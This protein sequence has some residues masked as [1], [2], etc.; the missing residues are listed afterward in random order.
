MNNITLAGT[1][2]TSPSAAFAELRERPR[3][4]TLLIV[5]I[6]ALA[7]QQFWFFN[8]V[9]FEWLKDHMFSG[10]ERFDSMQP[11]ARERMMSGMTLNMMMWS[12]V[13]SVVIMI[14]V[15]MA[16]VSLYYLLAG[17]VTNVQMSYKHWFSLTTWTSLPMLIG[18]AAGC[19]ILLAQGN[20][21][22]IG[23]SELQVLSLNELFFQLPPS[24]PGAQLLIQI[25][26]VAIWTWVLAIVGV[27]AWSNRTWLFATAFV[28][29]PIVLVYG[30]W[31]WLAFF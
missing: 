5:L 4:W 31:A 24:Q 17:K 15:M 29:L 14:P 2:L 16:V 9:D 26:A 28:M 19:A 21:A 10:N 7:A 3:F 11:E 6:V 1:M 13:V 25:N 18:I 20:D 30:V 8:A 27:K 12:S 22:Q 23:P